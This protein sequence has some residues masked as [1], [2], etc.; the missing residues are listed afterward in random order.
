MKSKT[1]NKKQG[2][3]LFFIGIAVLIITIANKFIKSYEWATIGIAIIFFTIGIFL[4]LK[5]RK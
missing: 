2:I 1:L 3:G 5:Y 4:V